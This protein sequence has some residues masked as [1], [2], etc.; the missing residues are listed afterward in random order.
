MKA[1]PRHP[2]DR[3]RP[4]GAALRASPP[5][6][7]ECVWRAISEPAELALWF[8]AKPL[9]TPARGETFESFGEHG[10]VTE[11]DPPRR[12]AWTCGVQR[13]S[14]DLHPD[15]DSCLL[16]LGRLD[17]LLAGSATGCASSCGPREPDA[18]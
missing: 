6:S 4:A 1:R 9:W 2:G 14:F 12:L 3:R 10:E 16:Y 17:A 8:V 7:V 5:H 15:A 11:L 18:C 13:F